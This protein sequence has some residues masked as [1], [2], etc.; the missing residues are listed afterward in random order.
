MTIAK[1]NRFWDKMM[2]VEVFKTNVSEPKFSADLI[3]QLLDNFPGSIVNFDME[4]CDKILRIEAETI[5]AEKVIEV[6]NVN[7]YYC[8]V[9]I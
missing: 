3:K 9:L 5:I 6:L 8:E 7:G 2:M 1:A 4:D